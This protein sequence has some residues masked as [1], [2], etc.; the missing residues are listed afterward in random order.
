MYYNLKDSSVYI[1]VIFKSQ[2]GPRKI[3]LKSPIENKP[4]FFIYYIFE[5]TVI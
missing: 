3:T 1:I 2:V 4:I 5:K